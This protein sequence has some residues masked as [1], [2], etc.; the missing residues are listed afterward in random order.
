MILPYDAKLSRMEFSETTRLFDLNSATKMAPE[1]R[2]AAI[3]PRR[4]AISY[5]NTDDVFSVHKRTRYP[6]SKNRSNSGSRSQIHGLRSPARFE[7]IEDDD[8]DGVQGR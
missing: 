1:H 5:A 6:P 2:I 4:Q 3:S 8:R 7:Q